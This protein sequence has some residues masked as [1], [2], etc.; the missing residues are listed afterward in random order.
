MLDRQQRHDLVM[1]KD[2]LAFRAEN[3]PDVEEAPGELRMTRLGLRHYERVPLPGQPPQV[4]GLR[5]RDVD[6]AFGGEL[7]VVEVEDLVIETLQGA[8]GYGD[9]PHRQVQARQPRRGLDEVRE[10]LEVRADLLAAPD[11]AHGGD[12]AQ[13]LVW[14]D[15]GESLRSFPRTHC[16]GL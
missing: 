9:E 1:P 4:V 6:R 11:A 15:H 16:A 14:L 2:H 5:A 10:V 12:E 8:F 3:E 13:G 7:L